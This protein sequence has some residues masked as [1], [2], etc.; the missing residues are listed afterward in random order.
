M[1]IIGLILY[2]NLSLL[3]CV[4]IHA[5]IQR[6]GAFDIG[7]GATKLQVSDVSASGKIIKT[8]FGEERPCSFGML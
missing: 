8:W 1:I 3:L 2:I 7:S 5:N 6:R 4:M